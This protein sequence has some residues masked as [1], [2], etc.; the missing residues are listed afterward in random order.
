[1]I[2]AVQFIGHELSRLSFYECVKSSLK[3]N[4][5]QPV[6]PEPPWDA[7]LRMDQKKKKPKNFLWQ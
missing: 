2:D 6:R 5:S 1:M 3:L 7:L 4:N